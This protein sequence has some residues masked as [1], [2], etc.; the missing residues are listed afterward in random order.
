MGALIENQLLPP[1]PYWVSVA[2]IPIVVI[3]NNP[4][5]SYLSHQFAIYK[6]TSYLKVTSSFKINL[7]KQNGVI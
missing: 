4:T 6:Y 2:D 5:T 7:K 3:D 1:P